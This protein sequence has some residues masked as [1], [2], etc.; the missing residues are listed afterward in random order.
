MNNVEKFSLIFGASCG[1]ANGN[2]HGAAVGIAIAS[3]ICAVLELIANI[4]TR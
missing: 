2:V 1:Y 3:G 4:K